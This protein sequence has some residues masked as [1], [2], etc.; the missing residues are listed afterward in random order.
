MAAGPPAAALA[1]IL[2]PST[3]VT[4]R[5][6]VYEADGVT[7]W[8]TASKPDIT[9]G[10][11]N[12]DLSRSERRTFDLTIDNTDGRFRHYPGGFWY[13][14]VLKIFRGVSYVEGGVRKEWETQLGEFVIDQIR[15]PHFP[16]VVQV[17]GRDYTKHLLTSKFASTTAFSPGQAVE[18]IIK[19][20]AQVAGISKFILPNRPDKRTGR[21]F[22][23][24]RG[25]ER[26]AAVKEIASAYNY[27]VFFDAQGF[28]VQA[29]FHDPVS[30][31]IAWT[32]ETGAFGNL[33][34][35][36]KSTTDSRIYNHVVVTGEAADQVPVSAEALNLEP[37]S[38]TRIRQPGETGGLADRL[39]QFTSSFIS[40]KAQA[41]EVAD[42]FLA[43]HALEEFAIDLSAI[44]LP[45]LDVGEIMEFLDPDPAPGDPTRF[46]L[47]TI[48]IPLALGP[49]DV[50]GR[51]VTLVG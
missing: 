25:V 11:V 40:T 39:Y 30:A 26:A 5:V 33:V 47:S 24:E 34:S 44:V 36:T 22:Q 35:Y 21:V 16:K 48:N 20:I 42:S 37:S 7:L 43:V 18:E 27:D 12:V 49:M 31:P 17:S 13:D 1:A 23:F 19:A 10:S 6:E 4:R 3:T 51:R 9:A 46:L 8:G 38:P 41:Q 14:K 50:L 32:F 28:M 45:W 2:G 29:P 15:E